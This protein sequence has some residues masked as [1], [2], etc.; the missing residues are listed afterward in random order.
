MAQ[1]GMSCHWK[2]LKVIFLWSCIIDA[3]HFYQTGFYL[4]PPFPLMT[5][6]KYFLNKFPTLPFSEQSHKHSDH[7]PLK[8]VL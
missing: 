6:Q 8:E 1:Y 4:Y 7:T 5:V 2:S 3:N